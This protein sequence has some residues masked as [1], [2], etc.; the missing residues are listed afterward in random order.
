VVD[1]QCHS[2]KIDR[3]NRVG[4]AAAGRAMA[5]PAVAAVVV[6]RRERAKLEP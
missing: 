1:F 4:P 3:H 2:L 5:G 6:Y